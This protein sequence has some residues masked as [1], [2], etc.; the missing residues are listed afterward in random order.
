MS[1]SQQLWIP[2]FH[3]SPRAAW[4]APF[5]MLCQPAAVVALTLSLSSLY[6][7]CPPRNVKPINRF[8][9]SPR[10]FDGREPRAG[11]TMRNGNLYGTTYAGGSGYGTVYQLTLHDSSWQFNVLYSF[12]GAP[13]DGAGPFA[14]VNFAQTACST[15]YPGGRRNKLQSV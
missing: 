9:R 14:R 1:H 11:L 2:T 4:I 8:T 3:I 6:S 7:V 13:N 10:G 12:A 5:T 15:V